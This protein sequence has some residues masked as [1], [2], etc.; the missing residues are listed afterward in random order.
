MYRCIYVCV[1]V[2]DYVCVCVTVVMAMCVHVCF[3]CTLLHVFYLYVCT[4][5]YMCVY[6]HV[7][8]YMK[9]KLAVLVN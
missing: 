4:Y 6:V 7:C 9:G 2:Y 8:V 5:M 1:C 3:M